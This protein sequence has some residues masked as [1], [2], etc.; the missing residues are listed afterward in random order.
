MNKMIPSASK[1]VSFIFADQC[2]HMINNKEIL[3]GLKGG[4]KNEK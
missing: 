1:D 4:T 3:N 2:L